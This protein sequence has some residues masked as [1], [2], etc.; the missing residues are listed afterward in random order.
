MEYRV[1]EFA[2]TA[3]LTQWL[4]DHAKEGWRLV[5]VA[6]REKVYVCFFERKKGTE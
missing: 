3:G 2:G 1:F 6:T 5:A 4:N